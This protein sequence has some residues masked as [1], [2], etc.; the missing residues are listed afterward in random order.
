MK[1]KQYLILNEGRSKPIEYDEFRKTLD[2][3]CSDAVSAFKKGK[4]LY[5]GLENSISFIYIDPKK[6]N[7]RR[8]YNTSN[9]YTLII[10][11]SPKWKKYPKRSQSLICSNNN[12]TA[13]GYGFVYAVFPYNGAN[14]GVCPTDDIW[15]SFKYKISHGLLNWLDSLEMLTRKYGVYLDDFSYKTLS[16]SLKEFDEQY[17]E[18]NDGWYQPSKFSKMEY[19]K[20]F[21]GY[22]PKKGL[23]KHIQTILDP[24]KNGFK[25]IN[26]LNKLPPSSDKK[27][28]WTDSKCLMAFDTTEWKL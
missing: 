11:N 25:L 20:W 23:E 19:E 22:D 6:G 24:D 7:P 14:F 28:I 1:F 13:A 4:K 12:S 8:S 10:D 5:R 2:S 18:I 15:T 27:E 26:S 9:H 17:I 21:K 16:R 3:K